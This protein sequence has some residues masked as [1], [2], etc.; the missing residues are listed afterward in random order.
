MLKIDEDA[1]ICDLAETY[2]IYNYKELP[3][4]TVALFCNG[5]REDSRIKLKMSGQ[6]ASI[7]ILLLASVVD[8]LSILVWSKTKDG[9]KGRNQPKSIVDIINKPIREKEG[10]SFNTGEEF[11]KMKLKILKGGG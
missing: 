10:M 2:H 6:R 1:V 8:R 7:D 3:P 4:L 11:E 5:L 9:Q